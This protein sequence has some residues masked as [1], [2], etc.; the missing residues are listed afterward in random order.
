[1]MNKHEVLATKQYRKGVLIL[2]IFFAGSMAPI[3]AAG[4]EHWLFTG[5]DYD[6]TFFS[7]SASSLESLVGDDNVAYFNSVGFDVSWYGFLGQEH[8]VGMYTSLGFLFPLDNAKDQML[9]PGASS[10]GTTRR[11]DFIFSILL[12]PAFRFRCTDRLA[13]YLGIGL[14]FAHHMTSETNTQGATTAEGITSFG[15]G[16]DAGFKL[17]I[18]DRICFRTGVSGSYDFAI[19]YTKSVTTPEH[20]YNNTS[21]FCLTNGFSI[22]PYVGMGIVL[23]T[24]AEQAKPRTV[25]LAALAVS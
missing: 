17:D 24:G 20:P 6:F 13:M 19:L 3:Y 15:A 2:M 12:G 23:R 10:D 9:D 5:F 7:S 8:D 16:L 22:S 18:T 4:Q 11:R 21:T 1:M 25:S 14:S